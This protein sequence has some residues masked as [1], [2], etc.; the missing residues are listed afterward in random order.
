MTEV[1][2]TD[3]VKEFKEY[4]ELLE[5][6]CKRKMVI[7]DPLRAQRKLTQVG[8]YRLSGYWYTAR[9]FD[10]VDGPTPEDKK[11]RKYK[12][13]FTLALLLKMSLTFICLINTYG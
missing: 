9:K 6:L 7:K 12:T 1:N 11:K 5:I 10:W 3:D 4:D 8:Y 2:S 13:N